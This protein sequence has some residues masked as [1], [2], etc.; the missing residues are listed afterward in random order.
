MLVDILVSCSTHTSTLVA[1]SALHAASM[2]PPLPSLMFHEPIDIVPVSFV[3]FPPFP[4]SRVRLASFEFSSA[5]AV[6]LPNPFSPLLGALGFH[7]VVVM[8]G[9]KVFSKDLLVGIFGSEQPT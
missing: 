8:L 9:A 5:L 7:G 3:L 2:P 6:L 4:V 1:S